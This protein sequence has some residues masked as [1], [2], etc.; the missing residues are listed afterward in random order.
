MNTT[1]RVRLPVFTAVGLALALVLVLAVAPHASSKPDG[2]ERVAADKGLDTN[3][4]S[5]ATASSPTAGYTVRGVGR[6]W[7]STGLAGVAGVAVTFGLTAS[8][9]V[10]L[11][12]RG[13]AGAETE[14]LGVS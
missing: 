11:R 7:L 2:L 13:R 12:R 1:S 3:E 9:L 8:V 6:D 10:L 4:R 14:A 5:S